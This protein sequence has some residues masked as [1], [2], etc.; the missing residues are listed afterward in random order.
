LNRRS[1]LARSKSSHEVPADTEG[2]GNREEV[3]DTGTSSSS[4]TSGNTDQAND[5]ESNESSLS[6]WARYLKNK[7][8]QR[9]K[10]GDA[11]D[12]NDAQQQQQQ[13]QQRQRRKSNI[14]DP[15]DAK[16][17]AAS[18]GVTSV[19]VA[20]NMSRNAY[21][22]KR[23]VQMKFGVRGSDQGSFTW[24]RGVAVGPDNS[25]VVAD[26]SNHRVQVTFSFAF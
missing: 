7:Y 17:D 21:M 6:T 12:T 20:S 24:P 22:Q 5:G 1:R 11:Q 18:S 9:N 14:Q 15:Q 4:H 3:G 2:S 25:I 10:D 16:Q 19:G 26:S 13:Q 8:G 23:R